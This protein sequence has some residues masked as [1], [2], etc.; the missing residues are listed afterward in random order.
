MSSPVPRADNIIALSLK[1]FIPYDSSHEYIYTK[2]KFYT[3]QNKT[4]YQKNLPTD[5]LMS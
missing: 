2:V 3:G 5:V 4:F 1:S